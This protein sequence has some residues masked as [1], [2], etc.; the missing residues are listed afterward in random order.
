MAGY[1][2][3]VEIM[4]ADF[5]TLAFDQI[6]NH[7]VKFPGMF[8]DTEIPLVIRTPAGGRRGYGPTHSQNPENLLCAVPGLT[9][10]F[11]SSRHRAGDLLW[12]SVFGWPYPVVFLEHK[13]LYGAAVGQSDYRVAEPASEDAGAELFPTLVSGDA[14]PDVTLVA[15]GGIV[16]MAEAAAAELRQEELRVEVI[17][18]ALLS[19]FPRGT[20]LRLLGKR[21]RVVAIEETYS[22]CG[23]SA[24]LGAALLE[25]GFTGRF[26]RVG[27]APV[28]IPAARSLESLVMPDQRRISESVLKLLGL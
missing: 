27:M 4:F 13:L 25:A 16:E 3:V 11:P 15:Y 6:Y 18:P 10:V 28:P 8:P 26:A 2:P 21:D 22:G 12:N 17:A 9:V 7:A 23:F 24:E 20:L 1:R 19:P 14:D 5:V